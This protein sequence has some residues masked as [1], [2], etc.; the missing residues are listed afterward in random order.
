MQYT[1]SFV[2]DQ[3]PEPGAGVITIGSSPSLS[4]RFALFWCYLNLQTGNYCH[5]QVDYSVF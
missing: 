2:L 5:D 3:S 4:S 1:N